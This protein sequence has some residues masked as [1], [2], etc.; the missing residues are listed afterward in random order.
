MSLSATP[1]E[2][3]LLCFP[4]PALPSWATSFNSAQAR[5]MDYS[6]GS[7]V[8][9]S[10]LE[11]RGGMLLEDW[12]EDL[13]TYNTIP[14]SSLADAFGDPLISAY[15]ARD[16]SGHIPEITLDISKVVSAWYSGSSNHGINLFYDTSSTPNAVWD[17]I[18]H[19]VNTDFGPAK[20]R[21]YYNW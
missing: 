17:W 13:V 2:V 21:V 8:Y 16:G 11:I 15:V 6:Y 7:A 14:G 9:P 12:S 5:F 19:E 20:L 4:L 1:Y 18:A 10:D 3:A